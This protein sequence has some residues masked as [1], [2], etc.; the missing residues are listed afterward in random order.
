MARI[1][2]VQINHPPHQLF[3]QLQLLVQQNDLL[4]EGDPLNGRLWGKGLEATYMLEEQIL[5]ITIL[6]KPWIVPWSVV[7]GLI[8][9]FFSGLS[10]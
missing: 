5:S 4:L 1:V 9:D 3:E 6:Q 7:E 8:E 2:T 10:Q